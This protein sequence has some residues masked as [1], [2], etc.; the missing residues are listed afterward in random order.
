MF[1]KITQIVKNKSVFNDSERKSM[2]LYYSKNITWICD[3][4]EV[5]QNKDFCNVGMP[6]EDNKILEFNEYQKFDKAPFKQILN[7]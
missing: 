2:A 6:S 5:C 4:W 1:Q 3:L 7:V